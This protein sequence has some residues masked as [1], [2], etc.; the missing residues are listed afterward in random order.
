MSF[1][2]M[3]EGHGNSRKLTIPFLFPETKAKSTPMCIRHIFA[4]LLHIL[5]IPMRQLQTLGPETDFRVPGRYYMEDESGYTGQYRSGR[6][7]R[8]NRR[9]WTRCSGGYAGESDFGVPC[10]ESVRGTVCIGFAAPTLRNRDVFDYRNH[11]YSGG[12][13]NLERKF[14]AYSVTLEQGFF[15]NKLAVEATF[16]NSVMRRLRTSSFRVDA[17]EYIRDL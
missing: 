1:I 16:D 10:P 7:S 2:P 11:I 3:R 6:H 5:T 8:R 4:L 17:T 14:D 9:L 12:I 15:D 13:D